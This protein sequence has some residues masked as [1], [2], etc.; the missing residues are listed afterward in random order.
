MGF[1]AAVAVQAKPNT[2]CCEQQGMPISANP[3]SDGH[4]PHRSTQKLKID[5]TN[6]D[7]GPLVSQGSV[8]HPYS[9]AEACKYAMKKNGCKDGALCDRCHQCE[10]RRNEKGRAAC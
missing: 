3:R 9:C 10:W 6:Q 5:A 2:Q 8:G 1:A 4:H 7:P